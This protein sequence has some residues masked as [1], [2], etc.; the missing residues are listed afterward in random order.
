MLS[1]NYQKAWTT[2]FMRLLGRWWPVSTGI[3]ALALFGLWEIF[4]LHVQEGRPGTPAEV[5]DFTSI[6]PPP[7]ATNIWIGSFRTG[8]GFSHYVRFEAPAVV[9][10]KY[11]SQ[12][13][14][15]SSLSPEIVPPDP[16]NVDQKYFSSLSWFDLSKATDV[17]GAEVGASVWVD[18]RR[19]VFYFYEGF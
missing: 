19:G 16:T 7:Q 6:M 15:Q 5:A 9:C 14:H 18:R 3:C 17:V 10:T 1:M 4:G 8:R 12:I 11:A 13:V 2:A